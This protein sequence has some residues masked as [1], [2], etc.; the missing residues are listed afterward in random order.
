MLAGTALLGK[1]IETVDGDSFD[2]F[3]TDLTPSQMKAFFDADDP[4]DLSA[5]V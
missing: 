5:A 2:Q 4:Y 3:V 1:A